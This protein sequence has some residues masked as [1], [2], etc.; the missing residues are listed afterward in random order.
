MLYTSRQ[1]IEL[2]DELVAGGAQVS[3]ETITSDHGHDGFLIEFA[4][5][6]PLVSAFLSDQ[7]KA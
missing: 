4:Q 1:Q 2:R 7:V 3:Y 5:L 6:D